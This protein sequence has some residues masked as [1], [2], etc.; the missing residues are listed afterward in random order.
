MSTQNTIHCASCC[1]WQKLILLKT[2]EHLK[3]CRFPGTQLKHLLTSPTEINRTCKL[4]M[5]SFGWTVALF[6]NR[7]NPK[8]RLWVQ[9]EFL[10]NLHI[11]H[12]CEV[13][14]EGKR[15]KI[16]MKFHFC[17]WKCFRIPPNFQST[18][19]QVDYGI[20]QF[21]IQQWLRYKISFVFCRFSV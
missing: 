8:A 7:W 3:C 16:D 2:A 1:S 10:G 18:L 15:A 5:L 4:Q 12:E 11:A 14:W 19:L 21:Q 6:H 9:T 13:S 20:L 17:S